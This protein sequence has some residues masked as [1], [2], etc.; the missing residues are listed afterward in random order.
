MDFKEQHIHPFTV[1]SRFSVALRQFTDLAKELEEGAD[2]SN[3]TLKSSYFELSNTMA[4]NCSAAAEGH[5]TA[6]ACVCRLRPELVQEFL[7]RALQPLYFLGVDEL[8]EFSSCIV[9]TARKDRTY[10][11][12]DTPERREFLLRLA[13][14][15]AA[16]EKALNEIRVEDH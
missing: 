3:E 16:L 10:L 5:L 4:T 2:I 6:L 11:D 8:E 15:V 9:D 13:D 7:P 1:G 12:L 14:D